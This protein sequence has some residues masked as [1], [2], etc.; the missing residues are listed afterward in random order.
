MRKVQVAVLEHSE[1]EGE[2]RWSMS[3][4]ALETKVRRLAKRLDLYAQKSRKDGL[5][6]V[7]NDRNALLWYES[8]TEGALAFLER[9]E[10]TPVGQPVR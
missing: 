10:R 1:G 6:Y 7:V 3:E 4:K 8:S 9:C 2:G 5:W